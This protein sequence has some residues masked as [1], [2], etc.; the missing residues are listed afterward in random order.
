MFDPL[1]DEFQPS[2]PFTTFQIVVKKSGRRWKWAVC[3]AAG[4]AL[5]IGSECS[6]AAASYKGQRSLFLLLASGQRRGVV[7]ERPERPDLLSR[8]AQAISLGHKQRAENRRAIESMRASR[9]TLQR[10]MQLQAA[11]AAVAT[12][13]AYVRMLLNSDTQPIVR[14]D[15]QH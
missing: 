1:Q 5:I 15:T 3:S 11:H 7:A 13:I 9:K 4:T 6:R 8:A 12:S 14:N 10:I 2:G